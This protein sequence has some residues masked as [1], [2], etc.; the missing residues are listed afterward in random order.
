M[1][2]K[3]ELLNVLDNINEAIDDLS[4]LM[5]EKIKN[6]EIDEYRSLK[7]VYDKLKGTV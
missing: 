4:I 5:R 1:T 2:I 7:A 6:N 3:Q